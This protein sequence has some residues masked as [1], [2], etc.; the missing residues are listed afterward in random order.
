MYIILI[1]SRRTKCWVGRFKPDERG[2]SYN[3]YARA[4]Q[5]TEDREN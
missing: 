3:I 4:W 1:V 2:D 5:P